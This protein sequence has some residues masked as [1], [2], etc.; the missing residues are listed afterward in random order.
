ME[1][2]LSGVITKKI[3]GNTKI[4]SGNFRAACVA[5]AEAIEMLTSIEN[6]GS[7]SDIK[8]NIQ[9]LNLNIY[10]VNPLRPVNYYNNRLNKLDIGFIAHEVQEYY[11]FLVSGDKDGKETQSLNYNGLIGIL[12]KE[13]QELKQRV[14]QLEDDSK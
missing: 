5:Y 8:E 14:K 4:A 13:I 3:D 12:V 1:S 2:K 9:D 10:N 7:I 6:L 11:P